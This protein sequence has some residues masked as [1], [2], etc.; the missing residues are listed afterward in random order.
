[1]TLQNH[2]I[3]TATQRLRL[4]VHVPP[5]RQNR[6]PATS[7]WRS[8]GRRCCA[9]PPRLRCSPVSRSRPRCLHLDGKI[10]LK[11]PRLVLY[12]P[13][14]RQCPSHSRTGLIRWVKIDHRGLPLGS[15][16]QTFRGASDSYTRPSRAKYC[17][18]TKINAPDLWSWMRTIHLI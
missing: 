16:L 5:D 15:P 4:I 3:D 13:I 1:M 2:R 10:G 18:R 11:I 14:S 12:N 6:K 17:D 9:P 7:S 8:A